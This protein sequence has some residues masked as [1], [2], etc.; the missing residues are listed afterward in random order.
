MLNRYWS[1]LFAML[2]PCGMVMANSDTIRQAQDSVVRL[3]VMT[4]E[5]KKH[6]TSY[7]SGFVVD[8]Q[9]RI[10]T[11]LHV[12]Q[13]A[14]DIFVVDRGIKDDDGKNARVIARSASLDLALLEAPAMTERAPLKIF[15][16]NPVEVAQTA[17]AI[18]F[19]GVADEVSQSREQIEANFIAPSVTNGIISKIATTKN[20]GD[21]STDVKILQH[22]AAVNHGNSGGPLLDDCGEVIGVNTQIDARD[23]NTINKALNVSELTEFL[24]KNNIKF[25]EGDGKCPSTSSTSSSLTASTENKI[26]LQTAASSGEKLSAGQ[27]AQSGLVSHFSSPAIIGLALMLAALAGFVLL[28][29]RQEEAKAKQSPAQ[30]AIPKR[31][32]KPK[33]KAAYLQG[34]DDFGQLRFSLIDERIQIGRSS[35]L[36]DYAIADDSVSRRHVD[37]RRENDQWWVEDLNTTNGTSLNGHALIPYQAEKLAANDVLQIG[38]SV[39]FVFNPT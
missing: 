27:R 10:V 6:V 15:K 20:W 30:A 34:L 13:G 38:K 23:G 5:G 3:V 31:V 25:A 26:N 18:G 21:E 35:T 36:N 7:G 14:T 16:G 24:S 17:W 22:S 33:D 4:Q 12:V 1:I 19:P 8:Q 2:L 29:L 11:N 39:R 9:G 37:L 28:F 32:V